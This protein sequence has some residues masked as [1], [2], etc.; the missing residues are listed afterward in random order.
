ME[1]NS[2][3]NSV[4]SQTGALLRRS[5]KTP[6]NF[7]RDHAHKGPLGVES[8]IK[9]MKT[10]ESKIPRPKFAHKTS[11]SIHSFSEQE[12]SLISGSNS[13]IGSYKKP[14]NYATN[15]ARAN[16]AKYMAPESFSKSMKYKPKLNYTINTAHRREEED[17]SVLKSVTNENE[18][19]DVPSEHYHGETP[20]KLSHRLSQDG[21]SKMSGKGKKHAFKNATNKISNGHARVRKSEVLNAKVTHTLHGLNLKKSTKLHPRQSIQSN[22]DFPEIDEH[23]DETQK[24]LF[25]QVLSKTEE[26]AELEN[27][28]RKLREQFKTDLESLNQEF[29]EAEKQLVTAMKQYVDVEDSVIELEQKDNNVHKQVHHLMSDYQAILDEIEREKQHQPEIFSQTS[30]IDHEISENDMEYQKVQAERDFKSHQLNEEIQ[31]IGNELDQALE[32]QLNIQLLSEK[33]YL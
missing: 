21:S 25:E 7:S 19:S 23:V 10:S 15:A 30:A 14:N 18:L 31:N 4:R 5:L 2:T 28:E 20:K 11:S 12:N 6:T 27:L 16:G 1:D 17:D 13:K 32:A 26:N 22:I 8:P 33:P 3:L 29:Q 24:S 9:S